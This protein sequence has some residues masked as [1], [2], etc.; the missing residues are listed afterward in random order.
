[1]GE[2]STKDNIE[3]AKTEAVFKV[4]KWSRSNDPAFL[5][6]NFR[7]QEKFAAGELNQSGGR[8]KYLYKMYILA[9]PGL[10]SCYHNVI[11]QMNT[12]CLRNLKA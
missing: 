3:P 12:W 9:H 5:T 2:K 6:G 10:N 1:M 11:L 8:Y 7:I 4:G